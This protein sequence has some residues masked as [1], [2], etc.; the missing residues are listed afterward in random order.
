MKL[1]FLLFVSIALVSA[2]VAEEAFLYSVNT[3]SFFNI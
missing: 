1:I 2:D 3:Y